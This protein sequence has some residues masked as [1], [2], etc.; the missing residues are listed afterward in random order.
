LAADLRLY[1]KSANKI[2]SLTL[3]VFSDSLCSFCTAE[4]HG[5]E[6]EKHRVI[7]IPADLIEY[8]KNLPECMIFFRLLQQKRE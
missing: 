6:T 4:L 5:E 2:I 1:P 7:K 8:V 3:C